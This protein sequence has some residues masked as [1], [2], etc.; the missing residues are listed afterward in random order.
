MRTFDNF[1]GRI[2]DHAELD[3]IFQE[4][5]IRHADRVPDAAPTARVLD[6]PVGSTWQCPRC[7]NPLD[8]VATSAYQD[9]WE[10]AQ[11]GYTRA[12]KQQEYGRK[13]N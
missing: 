2:I 6:E 5:K 4:M 9:L 11:C 1:S 3:R 8:I 12:L 10:C 13:N 7:G